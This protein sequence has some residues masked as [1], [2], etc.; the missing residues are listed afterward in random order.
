[1]FLWV[2]VWTWT[3]VFFD[4]MPRFARRDITRCARSD[5]VRQ[6][7]SRIM[8]TVILYSPCNLQ[9]AKRISL[10][11]QLSRVYA[12]HSPQGEYNWKTTNFCRNLPFFCEER[13][14][15]IFSRVFVWTW[16]HVPN[17]A[18]GVHIIKTK[19]CISPRRKPCISSLRK[20]IQPAADDIH[21]RWWDT[22]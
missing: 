7:A 18:A 2:F 6:F 9:R 1:M 20:R 15:K 8:L 16:T 17:R 14:K 21:L 13:T 11:K 5:I 10:A 12:Y 3:R 22:R 4:D 19:F